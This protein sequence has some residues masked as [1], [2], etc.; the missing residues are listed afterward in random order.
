MDPKD[1]LLLLL[2]CRSWVIYWALV[3]IQSRGHLDL[4][5]LQ[6][7]E[8]LNLSLWSR[9]RHRRGSKRQSVWGC[10]WDLNYVW[11]PYI[12]TET[13]QMKDI[14][15]TSPD[16]RPHCTRPDLVESSHPKPT[17]TRW[18]VRKTHRW[19]TKSQ[20]TTEN[21]RKFFCPIY[22]WKNERQRVL[23]TCDGR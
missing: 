11:G 19:R 23:Y 15:T 22:Q 18:I 20:P 14:Y 7:V 13:N 5:Q 8:I 16:C 4:Q 3:Q 17:S 21:G 2:V 6:E 10:F 12:R 9:R 1:V